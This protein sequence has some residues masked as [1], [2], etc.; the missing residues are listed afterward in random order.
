V[1]ALSNGGFCTCQSVH[2][3]TVMLLLFKHFKGAID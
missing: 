2:T 3:L 1:Y